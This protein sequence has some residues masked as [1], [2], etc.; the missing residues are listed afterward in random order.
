MAITGYTSS[1]T[2]NNVP[3]NTDTGQIINDGDMLYFNAIKQV[4]EART[5]IPT[6]ISGF[7]NDANYVS[8]EEVTGLIANIVSGGTLDLTEYATKSEL[9]TAISNINLFSGNYNDLIN[10]PAVTDPSTVYTRAQVDAILASRPVFS[11]SYTDLTNKPSMFSG[12]WNDL[13]NR[14]ILFN[15]DYSSLKN[16][17]DLS[18]YATTGYVDSVVDNRTIDGFTI[19]TITPAVV[20][21]AGHKLLPYDFGT[22]DI[23]ASNRR[24]GNIYINANS[25]IHIGFNQLGVSGANLTWNDQ[26][27]ATKLYVDNALVNVGSGSGSVDL[28]NY[29]TKTEFEARLLTFQP[30]VD[31]SEYALRTELFSGDYNDLINKPAIPDLNGYATINYVDSRIQVTLNDISSSLNLDQYI[32]TTELQTA[33][34][35]V[36]VFSGDYNDLVNKPVIFSGSYLDLV[37][38]PV[39]FNGDFSSLTNVPSFATQEYVDTAVTSALTG[40]TVDLSNYV[41]S[42]ILNTN[43]YDKSEIDTLLSNLG[44]GGSV[45][46]TGYATENYVSAYVTNAIAQAATGGTIN[47]DGYA[48]ESYVEQRLLERGDHFSGNYYELTNTPEL[49]SG[50]YNDLTNLPV[51]TEYTL[52]SDGSTLRFRETLSNTIVSEIDL[53][54]DLGIAFSGNYNDLTNKPNLFSGN[55]Y[56]LANKPYIPSIAGLASESYVNNRWA[57]PTI[58]GNRTFSNNVTFESFTKQKISTVNVEANKRNYVMAIQTANDIETEMLLPTGAKVAIEDGTTAMFTATVV[59][60]SDSTKHS[61]VIK[62]IIDNNNLTNQIVGSNIVETIAD[63]DLG[64]KTTISADETVDAMKITVTGSSTVIDWTIFLEITEVVR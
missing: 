62:G 9:S 54:A 44:A 58:T 1:D 21:D 19:D 61:A 15:G 4:F 53:D 63:S 6:G 55:Y 43:F 41:T 33:V 42:T 14:P 64:W 37:D 31:L 52:E 18:V 11:G 46:L 34:N 50:N 35:S 56:D 7:D 3:F 16:K 24:W 47:L 45:D 51:L 59:A 38:R 5:G 36:P 22:Q 20:F 26:A 29:V 49:F 13:R 48:T 23:G 25:E 32:T 2:D 12:S 39:L 8:Y 28:S 17:P 60:S 30:I 27:L 57:E 40:G 10:K